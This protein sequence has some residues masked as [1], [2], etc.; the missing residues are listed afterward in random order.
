MPNS[1]QP[2]I[3]AQNHKNSPDQIKTGSNNP[4][5]PIIKADS[6][7][8]I[9]KYQSLLDQKKQAEIDLRLRNLSKANTSNNDN[10]DKLDDV[11]KSLIILSIRGLI[12]ILIRELL[13]KRQEQ[14]DMESQQKS[15]TQ[16]CGK[17]LSIEPEKLVGEQKYTTIKPID[18]KKPEPVLESPESPQAKPQLPMGKA[19]TKQLET[20]YSPDIIA[21]LPITPSHAEKMS[22]FK[23]MGENTDQPY[24][25]RELN[26]DEKILVKELGGADL[27]S[28]KESKLN[29]YELSKYHPSLKV[30]EILLEKLPENQ[31]KSLEFL[32]LLSNLLQNIKHF[33]HNSPNGGFIA[34]RNSY[35]VY[36]ALEWAFKELEKSNL[37]GLELF[38]KVLFEIAENAESTSKANSSSGTQTEMNVPIESFIQDKIDWLNL[39][40]KLSQDLPKLLRSDFCPQNIEYKEWVESILNEK[41][42]VVLHQIIELLQ[43]KYNTNPKQSKLATKDIIQQELIKEGDQKSSKV[44]KEPV[45]I[46]APIS[47]SSQKPD[48]QTNSVYSNGQLGPL[49]PEKIKNEEIVDRQTIDIMSL[50]GA[51]EV[52]IGDEEWVASFLKF[53]IEAAAN[54]DI[55]LNSDSNTTMDFLYKNMDKFG[56]K[57]QSQFRKAWF[58][59]ARTSRTLPET[60]QFGLVAP[61]YEDAHEQKIDE[62]APVACFGDFAKM[63]GNYLRE[64]RETTSLDY[65]QNKTYQKFETLLLP[66]GAGPNKTIELISQNNPELSKTLAKLTD[67]FTDVHVKYPKK[68][69]LFESTSSRSFSAKSEFSGN[70]VNNKNTFNM[71]LTDSGVDITFSKHSSK[72]FYSKGQLIAQE[73]YENSAKTIKIDLDG[74]IIG[75]EER[76]VGGKNMSKLNPDNIKR[77]LE[78]R[79]K[80]LELSK[81]GDGSLRYSDTTLDAFMKSL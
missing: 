63:V 79:I 30:R 68:V 38:K 46:P 10:K 62:G 72:N 54:E 69:N 43:Q 34:M 25:Y 66:P 49:Q 78:H 53:V 27:F 75:F 37:P 28:I 60:L 73:T 47:H 3:A 17:L 20:Q 51:K 16:S 67:V 23:Q 80:H 52:F 35:A 76:N 56:F 55:S 32:N 57:T 2:K 15:S 77:Y 71:I 70:G 1:E 13:R 22:E 42:I 29:N 19:D 6:A 41:N 40:L 21:E 4:N 5:L 59:L 44:Q 74:K 50:P 33:Q 58:E 18:T 24:L 36:Q 45:L 8:E 9:R 12:L 31:Q 11:D 39:R 81:Y 26:E 61:N 48:T 7:I 14:L 64:L 65:H